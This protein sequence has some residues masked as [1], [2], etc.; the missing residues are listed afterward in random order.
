MRQRPTQR[1]D[2]QPRSVSIPTTTSA[3]SL[4]WPAM[5]SCSRATPA[6]PSGILSRANTSPSVAMTH[7]SWW[8]SVQSIPTSNTSRSLPVSTFAPGLEEAAAT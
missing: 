3:R 4:A 2:Q 7:T 1:P 8:R 6:T 5:S